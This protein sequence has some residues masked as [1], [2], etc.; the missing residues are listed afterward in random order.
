MSEPEDPVVEEATRVTEPA[1]AFAEPEILAELLPALA[2]LSVRAWLRGAAWGINT[3]VRTGR[4]LARAAVDPDAAADLVIDVR[5]ELRGYARE[6]LGVNEI[7]E[8]V[9]L[10]TGRRAAP[11]RCPAGGGATA[12]S[13]TARRCVSSA[14]NCS[15]RPPTSTT[16]TPPT[17]RTRGSSPSSP[18][19]KHA[20]C[21]CSPPTGRSR[22]STSGRRT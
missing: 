22:S 19:T 16:T 8:Q 1:D 3:S 18:R 10:L 14:P 21:G 13:P 4:R 15:S 2:R 6:F 12:G 17:P 11:A 5:K 20:S 9:Q 7:D